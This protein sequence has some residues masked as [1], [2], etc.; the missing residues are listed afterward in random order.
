MR[1]AAAACLLAGVAAGCGGHARAREVRAL[2]EPP[3]GCRVTVFF[4]TELAGGREPTRGE[5]GAVRQTLATSSRIKTFAFVS[6]RLAFRRMAK[7]EPGLVQGA[8]G[9]PLPA[10]YEIVPRSA[11]DARPLIAELRHARGVQRVS[12]ARSC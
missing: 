4:K 3:D 7:L 1:R 12:G 6:K 10:A 5:I 11:R 2:L 8:P 9:N